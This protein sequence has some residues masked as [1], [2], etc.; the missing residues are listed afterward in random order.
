MY[1]NVNLYS[2]FLGT[3][4]VIGSFPFL[5]MECI[6]CSKSS[7]NAQFVYYGAF[8]ALFQFGWAAVQVSHLSLIPDLTPISSER[9]ELNSL[10]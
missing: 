3:L 8:I 10:R 6:G 4:C 1:V 7:Q 9:V 2:C 5:F